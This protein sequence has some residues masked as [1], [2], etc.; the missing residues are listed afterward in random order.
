[1]PKQKK[2]TQHKTPSSPFNPQTQ[3]ARNESRTVAALER[4]SEAFRVLLWRAGKEHTISPIAVQILT[5]LRYHAPEQCTV[6]FMAQEFNMT[7]Q[8]VSE[9]V[10]TLDAKGLVEKLASPIDARSITLRLTDAG[11]ELSGKVGNFAE[12]LEKAVTMLDLSE[13]G[14]LL[15]GLLSLIR[16]LNTDGVVTT[17]RMCFT[18]RFYAESHAGHER[19]C[20]LLKQPLSVI[21]SPEQTTPIRLDCAEHQTV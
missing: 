10:V 1:M 11:M 9:A 7:K 19:Y 13:Q 14:T 17:Q 20:Q 2:T 5:F 12:P 4:L 18:C 16:T 15:G 6:G 3:I 21:S 8:T